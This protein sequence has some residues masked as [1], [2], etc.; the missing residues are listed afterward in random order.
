MSPDFPLFI[1]RVTSHYKR[2]SLRRQFRY[3]FIT[4]TFEA[5]GLDALH[6][7]LHGEY[8]VSITDGCTLS[9]YIEDGVI[10]CEASPATD[11]GGVGMQAGAWQG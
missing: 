11:G 3:P 4:V 6:Y 10:E 1:Y 7:N 2:E 8:T 9:L 5:L